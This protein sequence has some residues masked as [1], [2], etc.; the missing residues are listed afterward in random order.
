MRLHILS[1]SLF[2]L[3]DI[4]SWVDLA[5]FVTKLNF[6]FKQFYYQ[7]IINFFNFGT[8]VSRRL[9]FITL[10]TII[11]QIVAKTHENRTKS[12]IPP[13]RK[14]NLRGWLWNSE[15][16]KPLL[17]SDIPIDVSEWRR[18]KVAIGDWLIERSV[19]V[20][21]SSTQVNFAD[22]RKS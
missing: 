10:L 5:R 14:V 1:I 15:N 9:S 16:G 13:I 18:T 6:F 11:P 8:N 19:L 4:S 21:M 2:S 22:W 20:K 17:F 12:T 7:F 3:S